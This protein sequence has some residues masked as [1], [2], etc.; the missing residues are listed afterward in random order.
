MLM[1][2]TSLKRLDFIFKFIV[3]DFFVKKG[4]MSHRDREC[5]ILEMFYNKKHIRE[6]FVVENAFGMAF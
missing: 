1:I 3:M 2:P 6:K 5:D 4:Q